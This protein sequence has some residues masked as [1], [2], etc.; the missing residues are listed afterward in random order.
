MLAEHRAILN[1]REKLCRR[2]HLEAGDLRHQIERNEHL[3]QRLHL[4]GA[5]LQQQQLEAA[6]ARMRESGELRQRI[7]GLE[8]VSAERL[9]ALNEK[10]TELA[11]LRAALI[12]ERTQLELALEASRQRFWHKLAPSGWLKHRNQK[13]L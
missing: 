11:E 8:L 4:E 2:L 9:S 3:I 1:E 12:Q 13:R 10:E 5:D 7:A 6:A